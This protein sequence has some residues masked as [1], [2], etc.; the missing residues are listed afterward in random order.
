MIFT[1]TS[2]SWVSSGEKSQVKTSSHVTNGIKILEESSTRSESTLFPSF[3]KYSSRWISGS[4]ECFLTR[5][6]DHKA[7]GS[8][9]ASESTAFD[10]TC[11]LQKCRNSCQPE[12]KTSSH[13]TSRIK[14][15]KESTTMSEKAKPEKNSMNY[16]ST[17]K[18]PCYVLLVNYVSP[19]NYISLNLWAI[20]RTNT[21]TQSLHQR[22]R[23]RV[24]KLG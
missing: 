22:L 13:I 15:L 20:T 9:N 10:G 14:I 8:A 19:R 5:M 21:K 3:S 24:G 4:Q 12:V 23:F 17:M 18:L 6:V 7:S 1:S 16:W 2:T 11:C